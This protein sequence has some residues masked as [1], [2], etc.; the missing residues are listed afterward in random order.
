MNS[1]PSM[2]TMAP[3]ASLWASDAVQLHEISP[4]AMQLLPSQL[5]EPLTITSSKA[6]NDETHSS[7]LPS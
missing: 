7:R 6:R 4:S 5:A 3:W 1:P 2:K